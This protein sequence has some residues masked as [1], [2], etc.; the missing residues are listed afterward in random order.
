MAPVNI[1]II[2]KVQKSF[3]GNLY[4]RKNN[5]YPFMVSYRVKTDSFMMATLS[6]R[7]SYILSIILSLRAVI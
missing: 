4:V 1:D 2:E 6:A 3:L 5:A 7:I